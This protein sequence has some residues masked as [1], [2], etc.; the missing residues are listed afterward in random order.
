MPNHNNSGGRLTLLQKGSLM[1]GLVGHKVTLT[2]PDGK[3][4]E[5][6][7]ALLH[8]ALAAGF[9]LQQIIQWFVQHGP[10]IVQFLLQVLALFPKGAEVK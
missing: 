10:S 1:F 7:A 8:Q 3:S 6:P 9:S 4:L 2:T 5:L